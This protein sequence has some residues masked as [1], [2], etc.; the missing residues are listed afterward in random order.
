MGQFP[1]P[2]GM[3][4]AAEKITSVGNGKVSLRDR[5]T[6]FG[7]DTSGSDPQLPLNASGLL[8]PYRGL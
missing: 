2:W 1:A 3:G 7:C 5:V 4:N 8:I 6:S